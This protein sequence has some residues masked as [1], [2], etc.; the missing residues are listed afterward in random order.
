[1]PPESGDPPRLLNKFIGSSIS[2]NS[3]RP[4]V[5]GFGLSTTKA[6]TANLPT[7]SQG[8]SDDVA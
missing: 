8:G 1:M 5:P 7:L 6:N 2:H 4:L 3:S